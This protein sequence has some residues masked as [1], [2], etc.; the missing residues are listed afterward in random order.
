MQQ[1]HFSN[2]TPFVSS[3]NPSAKRWWRRPVCVA[4]HH[5]LSSL[6][7][8]QLPPKQNMNT[9][10]YG[11]L[12]TGALSKFLLL[13]SFLPIFSCSKPDLAFKDH[14]QSHFWSLLTIVT[15]L[16]FGPVLNYILPHPVSSCRLFLIPLSEFWLLTDLS[17]FGTP[18][19]TQHSKSR[20]LFPLN[21]TNHCK[22]G[23]ASISRLCY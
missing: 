3:I 23:F 22:W 2:H 5:C 11:S 12:L 21:W 16:A 17:Y 15:S 18:Y 1:N 14:L 13:L 8:C 10:P 7:T 4:R 20:C 6:L 19:S 9:V